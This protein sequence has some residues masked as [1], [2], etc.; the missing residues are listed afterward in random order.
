MP[1]PLYDYECSACGYRITLPCAPKDLRLPRWCPWC[2]RRTLRRI[3]ERS[4]T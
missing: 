4:S 2:V 1:D 3:E